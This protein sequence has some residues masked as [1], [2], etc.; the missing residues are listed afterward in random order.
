MA[1]VR[2]PARDPQ[3]HVQILTPAAPRVQASGGFPAASSPRIC[4]HFHQ[5]R[6]VTTHV[7]IPEQTRA[8]SHARPENTPSF[9]HVLPRTFFM[10][11]PELRES[12]P[13]DTHYTD[14][15]SKHVREHTGPCLR[16]RMTLRQS[17]LL[18]FAPLYRCLALKGQF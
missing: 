7:S 9:P 13:P 16:I 2:G 1:L 12:E 3:G 15:L 18:L 5:P 11:T 6:Q 10:K 8:R 14:P 17:Q 4:P